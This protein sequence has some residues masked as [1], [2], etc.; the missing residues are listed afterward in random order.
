MGA[1][2]PQLSAADVTNKGFMNELNINALGI[3][4]D[5]PF[6][7][8]TGVCVAGASGATAG[9]PAFVM[10]CKGDI[11]DVK[12]ITTKV[13]TGTGNTP[14]V[15][16]NYGATPTVV[17]QSAAIGL[18]GNIGDVTNVVVDSTK[19]EIAA[20]TVMTVDIVNPAGT[21]TVGLEGKFQIIWK[22]KA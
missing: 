9:I 7:I 15:R 6:I 21:I 3:L 2:F 19:A 14:V 12:F 10:P 8:P 22:P 5:F 11:V 16:L 17:A 13:Q 4:K 1:K 20:G 18:A